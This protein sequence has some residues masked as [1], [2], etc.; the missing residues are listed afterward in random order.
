MS[1]ASERIQVV[2]R[3]RP[4]KDGG[5]SSLTWRNQTLFVRSD[6]SQTAASFRCESFLDG[7]KSQEDAF[8]CSGM[9]SL[10][11]SAMDGF[12]CTVFA[13]GQTGAGKSHTIFGPPKT[14]DGEKMP[15][16]TQGFVR[17]SVALLMDAIT[18]E[19]WKTFRLR[20]GCV[21]IY[22]DQVHDL[23]ASKAQYALNTTLSIRWT[24]GQGF[25]LE[26]AC[27]VA[28]ET[29][30]DVMDVIT[31]AAS[32]RVHSSHHLNER[33]N[34]SHCLVTIYIDSESTNTG[35]R[36][37]GKLTIVDLAGS[38]R[39]QDTGATGTQLKESGQINKSLYCLSQVILAL[40]SH[41]KD[42]FV[43]YRDSK[44][45]TLLID[46]LGGHSRTLMLACV[47]GS[48]AFARETIR[49]L[50]FAM[51]VARIHNRPTEQLVSELK[52]QI[53]V[54][55]M[56]NEA[57]RI[58]QVTHDVGDSRG[59]PTSEECTVAMEARSITCSNAREKETLNNDTSRR[60]LSEQT[61]TSNAL[62]TVD[63]MS[64][65]ND[66][67][68]PSMQSEQQ[69]Q[70][71]RQPRH[72]KRNGNPAKPKRKKSRRLP[73]SFDESN[74]YKLPV[75]E[76]KEESPAIALVEHPAA[77]LPRKSHAG[78]VNCSSISMP[79]LHMTRSPLQRTC[80]STTSLTDA[81]PLLLKPNHDSSPPPRDRSNVG[82]MMERPEGGGETPRGNA[83]R[84]E[85][86][87]PVPSKDEWEDQRA[88]DLF[89]QLCNI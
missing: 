56:E 68:K 83:T 43:P 2:V 76:N 11:H 81:L 53:K 70:L 77:M 7:T 57:L 48:P 42:K 61:E 21:E 18:S 29:F 17:R 62:P 88:L 9:S 49:T 10:V 51:G 85:P 27:I 32:N 37:Y 23:V 31:L 45:T 86:L 41:K 80:A 55:Q 12:S 5:L 16:S 47:N 58:N 19:G 65:H 15:A 28:C 38:E 25:Y 33:S 67:D 84:L 73:A 54:L 36:K 69:Q 74:P 71:P 64:D 13:Y 75:M 1:S 30:D 60:P 59:R 34:R 79:T 46:S 63:W 72:T 24:K 89:L 40:N 22:N 8:A 14:G 82:L 66:Q 52:W 26:Q 39:A 44:L 6:G 50:E 4:T 35:E 78:C 87:L 3:A 20:V